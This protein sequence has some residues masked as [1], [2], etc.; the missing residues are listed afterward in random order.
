MCVHQQHTLHRTTE[1]CHFLRRSW[2]C[3][4]LSLPR[5]IAELMAVC[6]WMKER[7]REL[8][9]QFQFPHITPRKNK[10]DTIQDIIKNSFS[11]L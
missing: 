8:A 11:V 10:R 1:F 5:D 7:G 6:K 3:W 2:L 9:G 4:I